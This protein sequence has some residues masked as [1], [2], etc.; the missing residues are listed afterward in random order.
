MYLAFS[1]SGTGRKPWVPTRERV[2]LD[3]VALDRVAL[4]RVALDRLSA[5]HQHTL[6]ELGLSQPLTFLTAPALPGV[7]YGTRWAFDPETLVGLAIG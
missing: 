5:R 3:R 4:D 2:A 6:Q 1:K 7:M